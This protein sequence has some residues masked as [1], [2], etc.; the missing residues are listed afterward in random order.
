VLATGFPFRAHQLLDPYLAIFLDVF[1]RSKA[2]RRPGAAALDLAY[3]SCG[4]FDG[5]FEFK[6]S[7]WDVAAGALMV[8]EAGGE[9]TD[10]DG[11]SDFLSSGNVL[12]GTNGVHTELLEIVTNHRNEWHSET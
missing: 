8:E 11:G 1:L 9:V 6:L 10:M 12:C 3:V 4:I 7:A 5:F 2:I